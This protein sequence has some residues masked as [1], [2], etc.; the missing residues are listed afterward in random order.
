[1]FIKRVFV[2]TENTRTGVYNYSN[3]DIVEEVETAGVLS[4]DEFRYF[5]VSEKL[6]S[7]K[8]AIA[9]S[10]SLYLC[11]VLTSFTFFKL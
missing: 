3:G 10:T 8:S 5:W 7:F 11:L 1:M 4:C 2:S 9:S 6:V